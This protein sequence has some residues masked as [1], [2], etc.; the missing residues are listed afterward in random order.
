MLPTTPLCCTRPAYRLLGRHLA[1]VASSEGLFCGAMAIA[2]HQMPAAEAEPVRA[3]LDGLAARVR[4][5]V[6]GSQPQA[7]L[8]HLHEVLFEEEGYTGNQQN[9][10]DPANS[11]LPAVLQNRRGLP[12]TLSLV[13]KLVA[14]RIGLR[15]WGVGL[16]GHFIVGV[17][18][19]PAA[20]DGH[21]IL[22]DPFDGGRVLSE[23]DARDRVA[24]QFGDGVEW[25][26]S[27]L[28]PLSH[29]HWLTRMLQNLLNL[30]GAQDRF[31]DV[32]AMLEMEMLIWPDQ[33]QLQ[34]DLGF[35]AGP[36][37]TPTTGGHVA[38]SLPERQPRRSAN[39]RAPAAPR[40]IAMT[41]ER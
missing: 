11:Y 18:D 19:A 32:A 12:I 40:R 1:G 23:S 16:P 9:Y 15:C 4:G 39:V 30:F 34:R 2:M 22:V 29:R 13:Y 8:A 35:S 21:T 6:L 24:A 14:D 33:P 41:F 38:R 28:R 5:R 3:H 25:S 31:S 7:L 37:R 10:F 20:A 17:N 27:L 36:L 26:P